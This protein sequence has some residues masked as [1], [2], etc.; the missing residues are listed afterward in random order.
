MATGTRRKLQDNVQETPS[1]SQ[2]VAGE[3]QEMNGPSRDFES[4]QDTGSRQGRSL[5]PRDKDGGASELLRREFSDPQRLARKLGWFSVGLGL[6]EV[7]APKAV[8]RLIGVK[9]RNASTI[10]LF[11]VREIASG[12]AIFAQGE[13]PAAAVWSRVAGDAIDLAGLGVAFTSPQNNKG[14]L[15][16]VTAKVAAITAVDIT[17]AK[18]LSETENGFAFG[19]QAS[20]IRSLIIDRPPE[21]L[22]Q[23]WHQFENLPKFIPNL[24]SVE[25]V[26]QN[27]WHWVANG[28]RGTKV[29]WDA[30]VVDVRPNEHICWQS[31]AGSDVSHRGSIRFE[32][33]PGGRGTIVKVELDYKLPGGSFGRGLAQLFG[34][35]P[36]Q[37]AMEALRRFKQFVE[38]G[39]VVASESTIFSNSWLG[40]RP[41]QPV[42]DAQKMSKQIQARPASAEHQHSL[43]RTE[44]QHAS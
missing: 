14:K 33:A 36:S 4:A 10:R 44:E 25:S 31:L 39:E 17:C 13:R 19:S 9:R 3:N 11:G 41:A 42:G 30:E 15:A 26:G 29:E 18:R 34:Q 43:L 27:R 7:L 35:D 1:P 24:R 8:A 2:P 28:P 32:G 22:Y 6:A 21:E 12:I 5:R 38:T 40:Q 20:S 23:T 16:L 37:R